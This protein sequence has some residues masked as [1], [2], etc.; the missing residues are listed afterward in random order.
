MPTQLLVRSVYSLLSSMCS[1]EG[2]ISKCKALGYKSVAIVDKDV[3]Q[4]SMAFYKA[5]KKEE[6]KPI[7]GLEITIKVED[8]EHNCILYAKNNDG[9]KNLMALSSKINCEGLEYVSLELLNIYKN[10]N[11]L[12]L[13][14]DDCPL[15]YEI[16]K[17]NNIED[18][19]N[20]MKDY[21]GDNY[22]VGLVD[23]DIA[24]NHRR[25]KKLKEELKKYNIKTIA[26]S[27]TYYLEKDDAYEYEIL[28][29]IRDKR[30]LEKDA[31][32]E[33]GRHF[34]SKEEFSS[35]YDIEDIK[36]T[37][38]LSS[39]CNVDIDF[40]TSLPKYK[41]PNDVLSKDYLVSLSKAGL[42]RR[43]HDVVK[44][45]YNKRLDYELSVIIKMHFEDYFLI[46]YDFILFAKKSGIM[47]GPARGSAGGSLVA[48][49]LGIT[50][51]D[52]IKYGLLFERFLNPERISMPDID[53]DF[54]DDHRDE[55][56]E[57]VKNK[58]GVDHVAHIITYG[59]LKT[60]QVLRDVGRVLNY[61]TR[62][63]DSL[64]KPIPTYPH[65]TLDAAYNE[66]PLFRQKI[67]ADKKY[68]DLF[69]IA[70]KLEGFPRHTST[71]AAGIVFSS[72]NL[73]EVVPITKIESDIYSTQYTMEHL[74]EMGLI[75][76]DF[77]GL[78]NLGII[79]E[80]V[81]DINKNEDKNFDIKKIP[82]DDQKTFKLIDDVNLLGV[83]Q[84]ESSGMQNLARKMKPKNFE[85]LSMMIALFRP[86]PMENI[87]EFLANRENPSRIKYLTPELK[88]ILDETY[89]I[90][91]YQEQIMTIARVLAG[92]SYGKADVLRRAMSK[93]KL[94]ELEK[95]EPDFINGCIKNGQSKQTANSVYELILKFANY[96][97]NK[98]HSI[99]YGMVAY[100]M[101]YLKTNYPLYFYKAL[102]NGVLG[103][104]G[105]TYDYIKEC[106]K[107]NVK[108]K[109]VS[110]N[111]SDLVYK[112]VNNNI[113]M[114]FGVIKD[115]G[116]VAESK[117][118]EERNNGKFTDYVDTVLRLTIAGVEK[119]VIENLIAAGAFDELGHSR[120]TMLNGL[121][122]ALKYASTHKNGISIL[123]TIDDRPIL[124]E[125]KDNKQ[126][127][128]SKE[129]D[130]L[131]FYFSYNPILE[132]K[133][134]HMINVPS[135]SEVI[136][137][138][139]YVT[140]FG[141]VRRVHEHKTKRNELM[142]FM[143][144]IDDTGS[145]SLAIMPDVYRS[146]QGIIVKD[147]Y[148][149]FEGKLEKEDSV[150]VKKIKEA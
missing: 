119:N 100:E 61:Q 5:C 46:V 135:L 108:V 147:K 139:G 88:P 133:K 15:T 35:L 148:I 41:T 50:D 21:F 94:S 37:E 91:V 47:V 138:K 48:Y 95:L 106:E 57:Y 76:M 42:K 128:A 4:G 62:E 125:L 145:I 132:Y 150:L 143:D 69:K 34:L 77:L 122:N 60:K 58:Y 54:P 120:Y 129:K 43:L 136:N 71:H 112:I 64:T 82:L 40:K 29:C 103:S 102:L 113:L 92:F 127:L 68:R 31:V 27:R 11:F 26:L 2:I 12:V 51:I 73:S 111:N 117:I 70:K 1:I 13:F 25:D 3:L 104:E 87:P 134:E 28:K 14:S 74:E 65:I 83:F 17:N 8:K 33:T 6:I 56:F 49:C 86:G 23:H 36:N 38:V 89:G 116:V 98:S 115:V 16:D 20:K 24:I 75:K 105:K 45:E 131:G 123:S 53:T 149:I 90:I 81:D 39:L 114:P 109:G 146:I 101:A 137:T 9:F 107:V 63:L 79:A 84:L 126:V 130:V 52:P 93:K 72:E 18:A 67:E 110:I 124:E 59:T 19:L 7:F 32:L 78:R 44:D 30:I 80:I 97:F 141:I 66:I 55:V 99:A 144:I 10:N 121:E 85:E 118:I 140:G 142:A 22:L 96:G